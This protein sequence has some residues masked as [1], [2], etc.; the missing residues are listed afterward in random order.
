VAGVREPGYRSRAFEEARKAVGQI[1]ATLRAWTPAI[2]SAPR[3]FDASERIKTHEATSAVVRRPHQPLS[4]RQGMRR[5]NRGM[6]GL[7]KG[8]HAGAVEIVAESIPNIEGG[9]SSRSEIF[10]PHEESERVKRRDA[11]RKTGLRTASAE[12]SA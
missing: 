7:M 6:P 8:E 1:R 4:I 2:H 3:E 5:M 10:P 12:S 9:F 11:G